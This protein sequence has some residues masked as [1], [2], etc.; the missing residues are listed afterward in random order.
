MKNTIKTLLVLLAFLAM[1]TVAHAQLQP[2]F[3]TTSAAVSAGGTNTI[4]PITSATGFTAST[5]SQQNYILVD[6]ELMQVASISGTNLTVRRAQAG[7]NNVGHKSGARVFFGNVG[8]FNTAT[9]NVGGNGVPIFIGAGGSTPSGSCT[10][11]NMSYLPVF[12][13]ST[14]Y[15]NGF[16]YDCL[17]GQWVQG[18]LPDHPDVAPL[19]SACTVPVGSVAYASMGTSTA[20]TADKSMRATVY[21]PQTTV[22]TGIKFLA[23]ATATTDNMSVALFDSAG[24]RIVTGAAASIILAGASTFQTHAFALNRNGVTAQTTTIVVGPAKYWIGLTGNGATA[25]AYNLIAASTFNSV[26]TDS[27]TAQTFGT[28]PDFTPVATFTATVG[29]I[30]CLYQ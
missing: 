6:R 25:G 2:A 19:A 7:T 21:V 18:T 8:S 14:G 15:E 11:A 4:V 28:W 12:S 3:T 1:S 10:R 13:L 9:G 30:A 16:T 23:G 29:P 27:A 17:G 20:D 24:K 5:T 26:Q 22:F